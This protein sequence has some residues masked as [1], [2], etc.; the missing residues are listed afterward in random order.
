MHAWWLAC[1]LH[2]KNMMQ[3][4]QREAKRIPRYIP[5]GCHLDPLADHSNAQSEHQIW[6]LQA[7]RMNEG[8]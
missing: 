2:A 1:P 8:S 7:G 3:Q 4:Q 6:V 5:L